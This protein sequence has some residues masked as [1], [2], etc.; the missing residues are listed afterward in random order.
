VRECRRAAM[1]IAKRV[2]MPMSPW[3]QLWCVR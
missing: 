3:Q 1:K 2:A